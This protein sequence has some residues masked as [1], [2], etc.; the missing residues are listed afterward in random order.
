M[1]LSKPFHEDMKRLGLVTTKSNLNAIHLAPLVAEWKGVGNP[2]LAFGGRR[3]QTIGLDI[4]ANETGNYNANIVGTSGTGKSTFLQ[5]LLWSYAASG[6]QVFAYDLGRSQER[7]C[8]VLGGTYVDIGSDESQCYNPFTSVQDIMEDVAIIKALCAIMASPRG[9]LDD[10]QYQALETAI[11]IAFGKFGNDCTITNVAEVLETGRLRDQEATVDRRLTDMAVMLEPYT[12]RGAYARYFEGR[13][14]FDFK[15]DFYVFENESLIRKPDLHAV[16]TLLSLYNITGA[17]FL[18]RN[19][20]KIFS[21]DEFKQQLAGA[22]ANTPY[23]ADAV[24][25]ASLRARK[26][27]GGIITATQFPEHYYDSPAGLAAWNA[28]DWKFLSRLNAE[29]LDA[30]KASGRMN[31]S[32]YKRKIY[33]SLTLVAN[34]Y[35]EWYV[36]SPIGEGVVRS[37]IDPYTLLLFSNKQSD[38]A[39][40]DDLIAQGYSIDEAVDAVLR[41][42]GVIQ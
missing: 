33:G 31:P 35:S 28:A 12:K 17:M 10:Y 36:S 13:A 27:G 7:L 21:I 38:N 3:G 32:D 8:K 41:Q 5:D 2:V 11:L 18:N 40:L 15:A 39:P 30:L 1:T 14:T 16:L 23:M 37:I 25:A 22:G 19:R 9:H 20:R 34:A 24:S 26:Y 6:T 42:R 29:N 4:F